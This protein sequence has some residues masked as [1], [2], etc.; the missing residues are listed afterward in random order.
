[1]LYCHVEINY[2]TKITRFF[3]PLKWEVIGKMSNK[4]EVAWWL[5]MHPVGCPGKVSSAHATHFPWSFLG[6]SAQLT[7]AGFACWGFLGRGVLLLLCYTYKQASGQ[8]CCSIRGWRQGGIYLRVLLPSRGM[9]PS[10]HILTNIF[11]SASTLFGLYYLEPDD[12]GT[13]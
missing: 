10:L 2:F 9:S 12:F 11:I 3:L 7:K 8:T 5:L 6:P 4:K 13:R 1:M